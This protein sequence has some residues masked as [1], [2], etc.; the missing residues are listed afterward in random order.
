VFIIIITLVGKRTPPPPED[1]TN[2][3]SGK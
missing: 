1:F 3:A 2:S